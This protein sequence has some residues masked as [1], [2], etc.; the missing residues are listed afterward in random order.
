[1]TDEHPDVILARP[2]LSDMAIVAFSSRGARHFNYHNILDSIPASKLLVRDPSDCWYNAGIPGVGDTVD[3]IAERLREELE[4]MGAKRVFTVGSSMG[5]Y[6]AIL[7]G[8]LVGAERAMAFAPQTLLDPMFALSPPGDIPLEAPDLEPI[9]RAAT[10]TKIDLVV[11]WDD[12]VDLF[13]YFHLEHIPSVRGLA[14][15]GGSHTF[16]ESL[17]TGL[18]QIIATLM[19]GGSPADFEVQ[20]SVDEELKVGVTEAVLA[21]HRTE[22]AR[23]ASL[24]APLAHADPSWAALHFLH[25]LACFNAWDLAGAEAAFSAASRASPDWYEPLGHLGRTLIQMQRPAD[26]EPLLRRAV[27]LKPDWARIYLF[28]GESLLGQGRVEEARA[29]FDHALEL[30]PRMS[31]DVEAIL[32]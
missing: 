11:G 18:P 12:P 13:Y 19:E 27:E 4:A 16:I 26:A 6:A 30:D 5:A 15:I 29:E 17:G 9:A 25:G 8:C 21:F 14:R 1:M 2:Q 28:L 31:T 3:Q 10:G 7:F 24:I 20:V 23:S 32:R 22:Y